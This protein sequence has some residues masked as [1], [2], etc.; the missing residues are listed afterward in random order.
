MFIKFGKI[1]LGFEWN[2]K[3]QKRCW[4]FQIV[5][6]T[7]ILFHPLL[8]AMLNI[9][10]YQLFTFHLNPFYIFSYHS[11]FDSHRSLFAPFTNNLSIKRPRLLIPLIPFTTF[12][13]LKPFLISNHAH[14]TQFIF[15]FTHSLHSFIYLS[16]HSLH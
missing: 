1:Y 10:L 9:Y 6:T 8:S 5:F 12:L 14:F 15:L 16:I 7:F 2:S 11:Q 4:P 3:L 13:L